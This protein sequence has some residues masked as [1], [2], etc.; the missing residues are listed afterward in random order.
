MITQVTLT[1]QRLE[2]LPGPPAT[3]GPVGAQV[4]FLGIVRSEEN[5]RPIAALEYEAYQPMAECEI[6]RLL[7]E[8]GS[9]HPCHTVQ[10][11]H[12]LGIVPVG[13]AA[14]IVRVLAAHRQ[15]AFSLLA[16]FMDRLK[17][18]VPIW[19]CKA[20]TREELARRFHPGPFRPS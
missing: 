19:K 11:L 7:N 8:L 14:I 6:E 5:G 2:E 12:R 17:Q 1:T 18:D 15:E 20:W 10:V 16:R 3:A 4:E 9:A 13:E